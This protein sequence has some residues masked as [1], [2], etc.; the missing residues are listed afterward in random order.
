MHFRHLLDIAPS[1]LRAAERFLASDAAITPRDV[2]AAFRGP[3]ADSAD[4]LPCLSVRSGWH[5]LLGTLGLAPGDEVVMSGVSIPAM[6]RIPEAHGLVVRPVDI[7]PATLAPP[8]DAVARA[9]GP[10]TRVLVIAHLYGSRIDLRPYAALARAH[11]LRL[12]EDCAQAFVGPGWM[13]HRCADVALFSFGMVKTATA[14][15]GAV[16]VVRDPDLA[17]RLR[18]AHAAWPVQPRAVFRGKLDT[19]RRVLALT[20]PGPFGRFA[21]ACA[22]RGDDLDRVINGSVR[23]FPGSDLLGRIAHRP[24]APLLALLHRRLA[25]WD[26]VRLAARARRGDALSARLPVGL[27]HPGDRAAH[28]THWLFPIRS[29]DPRGL[30]R[31]LRTAGFDATPGTTSIAALAPTGTASPVPRGRRMLAESIYVPAYPELPAAAVDRLVATLAAHAA[32]YV[33]GECA[34]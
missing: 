30:V 1:D 9:I 21:A 3:G 27:T 7:D 26:G 18:A 22:A 10:R 29:A 11:G 33:T 13:G 15:A 31:A 34:K 6:A 24:S 23:G 25:R 32:D 19:A 4:L 17:T 12:V 14:L 28:R 5:L 16:M 20:P 8:V 2:A